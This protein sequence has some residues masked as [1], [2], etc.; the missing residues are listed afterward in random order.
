MTDDT[1]QTVKPNEADSEATGDAEPAAEQSAVGKRVNSKV[2]RKLV[3]GH[4]EYVDDI[5]KPGMRHAAFVRSECAH[6]RI[7]D[8]DTSTAEAMPGVELVWT[9][10]D[11]DPY[12]ERYSHPALDTPDEEAL[13]TDRV[14]YEGEEIAVVLARDRATARRAVEAVEVEYDRLEAVT[15]A[16][17]ALADDAPVLHPELSDD[18]DCA[19]TGNVVGE[20][21]VVTGDVEQGFNTADVV[22]EGTFRTNKT[23]PSPLEP[24]GVVA[25][26]NPG[27]HELELWSSNQ[28]PHLLK[29]FLAAAVPAFDPQDVVCKMPDIGGGFGVKMEL[30]S[31]EICAAVLSMVTERPVKIVLNRTEELRVGRGRHPETIDARLGFREDGSIVAWEADLVQNTGA[32]ATLGKSVAASSMVTS[33]GPY[34]IP[35]QQ[36]SGTIVY[37]N[38]M[39][40]TAVRGYGDPQLTFAREQLVDIAAE[41]LGVDAIELRHRNVPDRAD[42]PM[43]SPT[44]LRWTNADMPECLERVADAINWD[45]HRGGYRTRD[46]ML[47]GVGL[48]TIMKRG[49]NKDAM[50]ADYSSS[51][52][53]LDRRGEITVYTGITSIGQGTE[54]GIVQLVA[55]VL[56]VSVDRVTP[57]VG[58]SDVT[59]DDMGVW[60]DRGAIICGTAAS[61]AAEDLEG[62]LRTLAAHYLDV[63]EDAIV[64][65]GDRVYQRGNREHGLDIEELAHEATIGDPEDR[66][67]EFRDGVSLVGTAKFETNRGETLDPETGTGNLSHGY[68]F[69]ALATL[70][71]VDPA[72]GEI[73]VVDVAICEDLGKVI[74]PTLVEGQVQ[75]GIVHAMGEA[76][77]EEMVYDDEG[78]LDNGTFIEYHPPTASDVPMITNIH[79]LENPDPATSHGQK[80]VGEC[81]TVPVTAAIANAVADATGVRFDE[82]PLAPK[83]VLPELVDHDV[84]ELS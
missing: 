5:S 36:L 83:N 78:R 41:K 13:A 73:D 61:R 44:G 3:T 29:E 40:G 49:G 75:G 68:T 22:V 10:D 64:F 21:E 7:V 47:R 74:N 26:Y 45:E 60:A 31:H 9:A 28:H 46:G 34:V 1:A 15:D 65:A 6:A 14:L 2:G 55:D 51:I 69:G 16:S 39:P 53:E 4:G 50:G 23:N 42:M 35:N 72:T 52:V 67:E 20:H 66:P 62:R 8:V 33:A 56:G 37:T 19:V 12:V 54:T 11:I 59:P 71:E 84:Y 76:L 17:S 58:D 63:D 79:E 81:A 18:P 77:Y 80:G 24:H 43:R 27:D 30:F 48:G 38:V 32:Y 82:L 70:V 57:I 25:E